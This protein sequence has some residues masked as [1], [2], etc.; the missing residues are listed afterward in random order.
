MKILARTMV[1]PPPA[2]RCRI[3]KDTEEKRQEPA[4]EVHCLKTP[5]TGAM[6]RPAT[7]QHTTLIFNGQRPLEP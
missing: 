4:V 7:P 1:K 2:P 6:G 5:F 3:N